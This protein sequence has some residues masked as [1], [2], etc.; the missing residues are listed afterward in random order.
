MKK[1]LLSIMLMLVMALSLVACG[2]KAGADAKASAKNVL[3]Q[4]IKA[5]TNT[6]NCELELTSGEEVMSFRITGANKDESNGYAVIEMK[7]TMDPY[8]MEDYAELT[9]I[10]VVNGKEFYIDIQQFL[11]FMT[12]LDS[13]FA[14]LSSYLKLPGEYLVVTLEDILALYESMGIDTSELDFESLGD[15]KANEAYSKAVIEVLGAFVDEFAGKAGESTVQ[16]SDS[17]VA[18]KVNNDNIQAVMDAL[19][20]MDVE[21][22]FMDLAERIDKIENSVTNTA[23][24]KE[25]VTGWNDAIKASAEDLKSNGLGDDKMD[26]VF[27]M[28]MNGNNVEMNMNMNIDDS[29][30]VVVMNMSFV[31][32]P[33]KAQD[34]S[35]PA[36]SMDLDTF[37]Q[38]L[39][40][41]GI[42]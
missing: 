22:Y 6:V 15:S 34:F 36:S 30:E 4:I 38:M 35:I 14:M 27:N 10:Y 32:T 9:N 42:M 28:G 39:S 21:N 12:E 20:A 40:E 25:E 41:L 7:M 26:I 29:G 8:V 11:D 19:A 23:A 3:D 16:I 13:Q 18:I 1:R 17:K 5:E 2:K 24:M 31:T 33:D 37:M